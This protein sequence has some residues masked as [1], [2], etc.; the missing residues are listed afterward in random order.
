[1]IIGSCLS[2]L[3]QTEIS[4]PLLLLVMFV[5]I[6]QPAVG[7]L[8]SLDIYPT[9]ITKISTTVQI[10]PGELKQTFNPIFCTPPVK[11]KERC[12]CSLQPSHG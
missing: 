11:A 5:L 7:Q 2:W 3:R 8:F 10:H 9:T 1:M 6:L 4:E 12:Y